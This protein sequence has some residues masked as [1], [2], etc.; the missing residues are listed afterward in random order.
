MITRLRPLRAF[1]S[2]LQIRWRWRFIAVTFSVVAVLA[3]HGFLAPQA[4]SA[5]QVVDLELVLAVDISRSM[6]PTEQRLQRDG[7]VSALRHPDVIRAIQSGPNGRI[8]LTYMEWAGHY[9]QSVTVPWRIIANAADAGAFADTLAAQPLSS[10]MMTS[11][12]G[13]VRRARELFELG[14]IEGLRR[15][16]DVSGDG[17]NNSGLPITEVR[18]EVVRSG[19]VINGLAIVLQ[20]PPGPF[21]YFEIPD[22]DRYY[23]DCVI[24]GPGS[25]TLAVTDKTEFAGAIRRKLILEIAGLPPPARRH[26]QHFDASAPTQV[27]YVPEQPRPPYDCLIGEKRWEQYQREQW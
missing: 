1:V 24:G 18:D 3:G 2:S 16:I 22:L 10:A 11:I 4:A 9:I 23:S 5:R 6:D 17:P 20:R 27:Q 14:D 15:V 25:F 26:G 19:I 8:A 7:Y 21:S 13:A 12:S